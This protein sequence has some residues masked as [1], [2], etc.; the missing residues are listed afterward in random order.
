MKTFAPLKI[1]FLFIFFTT[2]HLSADSGDRCSR[3]ENVTLNVD[4]STRLTNRAGSYGNRY[5]YYYYKFTPNSDGEITVTSS[6]LDY[7]T[8]TWL[9]GNLSDCENGNNILTSDTSYDDNVEISY[10][11]TAGQTYYLPLRNYVDHADRFT[12][13]ISFASNIPIVENADD[14]CYAS[15]SEECSGGG[16]FGGTCKTTVPINS[17]NETTD[18]TDLIVYFDTSS[19][20][21]MFGFGGI[22]DCSVDN[23]ALSENCDEHNNGNSVGPFSMFN[24]G[25]W[26]FELGTV[27]NA[28][29]RSISTY[30]NG[31]F[32]DLM[33]DWSSN[34]GAIESTYMKDGIRYRGVVRSCDDVIN[35]P[36]DP[37]ITTNLRDFEIRNPS[38]TRNIKGNI[39]VIGNTVLCV[40]SG[41]NCYD[42]QGG[43]SNAQLNLQYIDL[44]N[45]PVTYNSSQ[46]KL[47]MPNS[48]TVKW[49][50]LYTQGYLNGKNLT[51]SKTEAKKSTIISL[52]SVGDLS[53]TPM[54]IDLY[55]NGNNGYTYSTYTPLPTLAGVKAEDIN[56]WVTGAN[57]KSYTGTD[58]SGLG[59]FGAWTLVVV[60]EDQS[61]SLK[62]ISVF[63]GYRRVA[64][65]SGFKSVDID[66]DGF[67]TP[68]NGAVKSTLSIFAGEG[69]KNI[70]GDKLYVDGTG[71]NETNAFYSGTS[72]FLANPSYTNNQ[73]IDIQ[74]HAI[75]Q[76]GDNTHEQIIGNRQSSATITLTSSQDTYFPSVA[77]FTT[78]LYEPRVCYYID[79]IK[80][81]AGDNIFEDAAFVG[82]ILPNEP[83]TY[84]I[85]IS[86]MKKDVN[87][88]D[89]ETAELVQIYL[90]THNFTY[91]Q[92]ETYIRNL[93]ESDYNKK[94][95]I[96]DNDIAEYNDETNTS[97]W[98]IGTGANGTQGGTLVPAE[99]FGDTSKIAY[100]QFNGYLTINED[101]E[102]INLVDYLELRASFKTDLVT[103]E[104][105]NAQL[106]T[107]CQDLNSSG[108]VGTV[109]SGAF[110]I[111]NQSFVG[112][113]DPIITSTSTAVERALNAIPTQVANKQIALRLLALDNDNI[114]LKEYT[115]DVNISIIATPNYDENRDEAYNQALCDNA[116]S[117]TTPEKISLNN[118][119]RKDIT[120]TNS[121]NAYQ[122]VSF[123]IEY[124]EDNQFT[125]SRD[126]FAIRPDKL[127]LTAPA[128]ED[129]DLLSAGKN[130][131]LSLIAEQF[132]NN[133]QTQGYTV[134]N[135]QTLFTN[136]DNNK[137]I[138]NKDGSD[139]TATLAGNL[140]FSPTNFDI[141][142]GSAANAV[143]LSFSDV[144]K[145]NI[146]LV[147][148]V[149]AQ[150]DIDNGDTPLD[151]SATGAY[152]CGD[153][154]ATF[155]PDHFA[156]TNAHLKNFAASTYTYLS[157]DLNI[158][159]GID[160]NV[161]AENFQNTATI[162]FTQGAWENPV[163]IALVLP[164]ITGMTENRSDIN[165]STLLNF[166]NGV[167]SITAADINSSTN[168]IFN[169]NRSNNSVV[170]PFK[171]RGD[172][173][174]INASSLYTNTTL[175]TLT[176][177]I[178]GSV[179]PDEE[180]TFLYART[181]APRYRFND[182]NATVSIYY[183]IYCSGTVLGNVCDTTLLPNSPNLSNSD[184]PRWF[185]NASHI[186]SSGNVGVVS[187]KGDNVITALPATGVSTASVQLSYDETKG[188]PY[189]TT[190]QNSASTWLIYNKYNPAAATN[191]FQIEFLNASS[192]WAGQTETN[193]STNNTAAS[194]TN[195]RSMW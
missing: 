91:T 176:K 99:S 48:A 191:E 78:E 146:L 164:S 113:I 160:L 174:T 36:E 190:M 50:A 7:D 130:Y 21:N 79:T 43:S 125:C 120:L 157:N 3:A 152:T 18:L 118:Q 75:G 116:V 86:N 96:D 151:C 173:V 136:L 132:G 186:A 111:V 49:A 156:L 158:S 35:P 24:N 39:A 17:L 10:D 90:T 62:N 110:N 68:T 94:T 188:F 106:I 153:I 128:G 194:I 170:N 119:D 27:T 45:N 101:S 150:V 59:N 105:E 114:T 107:Q 139:A 124:G 112:N 193:S 189:K 72:G 134:N 181:H 166:T 67:L 108:T 183:E 177:T 155:I 102:E 46:A 55:A 126:S 88:T 138:Y 28:Q 63:D 100:V 169:Y 53:V 129:I 147:D 65:S 34:E 180:A 47:Q 109:P 98:R 57:I 122:N 42:Y 76:D 143:G 85:W 38:N 54:L 44:D 32:F 92:N 64:N 171:V 15:S 30:D 9:Y 103:I 159:A 117:L 140:V 123:K 40:K 184:D 5:Y 22:D 11:V 25:G 135:A 51:Q 141:T 4:K 148:T 93:N 37:I 168:L 163:D 66:I 70:G 52:P 16:F 162:N 195:R 127:T 167:K 185:I 182:S 142:D 179:N 97:T 81:S 178:I 61:E 69:D 74:N 82:D 29:N 87:D 41:G 23:G 73:G 149:W 84:N 20:F 133:T 26:T 144:G 95:D 19:L 161:R 192:N 131:N 31:G 33:T 2:T 8:D 58:S 77:V 71:I 83:Y 6:N 13:N 172:T 137:T 175:P 12:L 104:S 145:V 80:D 154:N 14:I 115:G 121:T 165:N 187:Q 89:L 56:G 1:L 60:Y